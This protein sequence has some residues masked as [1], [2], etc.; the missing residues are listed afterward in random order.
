MEI[1]Y[2]ESKKIVCGG[3]LVYINNKVILLS[4]ALISLSGRNK[5]CIDS[6]I[7]ETLS[8]KK[9]IVYDKNEPT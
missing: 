3:A 1:C 5:D 7:F 6:V 8:N 9:Y 4:R 2:N